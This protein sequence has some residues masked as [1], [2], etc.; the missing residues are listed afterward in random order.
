MPIAFILIV[1]LVVFNAGLVD[2]VKNTEKEKVTEVIT[3]EVVKAKPAVNETKPV[4]KQPE[5]I[6]E[7]PRVEAKQPELIKEEPKVETK[8]SELIKEEPKVEAKQPEPIKETVKEKP[9]IEPQTLATEEAKINEPESN[10]LKIILYI[11]GAIAAIFGGFYYF[12]N[13]GRS[14]PTSSMV[15][16]AR[17]DIEENY[18]PE[19]QEQQSAQEENQTET[20]EQKPAQEETQPETEE[21]QS[22]EDEN[23]NK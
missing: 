12:S 9:K 1:G 5:T 3:P 10:Y 22:T 21:Q 8:Q 2:K 6:K 19:T 15:E 17:K 14:Q 13:R 18:Q 20:Q 23:N 16:A 7:E 4:V 11:I